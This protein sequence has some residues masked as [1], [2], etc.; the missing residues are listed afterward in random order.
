MES[1]AEADKKEL[2]DEWK[3]LVN[4]TASEI[5]TFYES[6]AGK[7]SGL[8]RDEAD[9]QD[10]KQG[11]ESARALMR[12]IPKA[13]S[14]KQAKEN[15]TDTDWEWVGAQVNFINRFKDQGHDLYEGEGED[16]KLTRYY[17]ALLIWGHKKDNDWKKYLDRN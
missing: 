7:E 6:N 4:M 17:M 12:M 14:F 5:E 15:F 1:K 16:K 9:S 3:E 2:F 11:R 8:D 10:I 13:G